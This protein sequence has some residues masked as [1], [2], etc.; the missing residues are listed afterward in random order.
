MYINY[1]MNQTCLPLELTAFLAEDR[2][3]YAIDRL[4]EE[5]P[6]SRFAAFYEEQGRP[7]YHPRVLTKVLLYA[8]SEGIFSGRRMEKK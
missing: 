8:Y 6:D 5:L 3:V 7:S 2:I 1:T 4:V